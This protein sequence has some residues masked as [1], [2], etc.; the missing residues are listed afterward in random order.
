MDFSVRPFPEA[1]YRMNHVMWF[2]QCSG[3]TY[4]PELTAKT[5]VDGRTRSSMASPV[6]LCPVEPP[7]RAFAHFWMSP[8]TKGETTRDSDME[9]YKI[10]LH[11]WT[12]IM[13]EKEK[14]KWFDIAA[15]D[16]ERYD[17]HMTSWLSNYVLQPDRD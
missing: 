5:M 3:L 15:K 14:V 6:E 9:D 12:R 2:I 11:V 8:I 4:K 7:N 17:S 16:R 13:T 1:K 10:A